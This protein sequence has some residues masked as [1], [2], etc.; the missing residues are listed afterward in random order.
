MIEKK[1]KDIIIKKINLITK[2]MNQKI[3]AK[4]CNISER[5]IFKIMH[6]QG[7]DG[8]FLVVDREVDKFIKELIVKLK[9]FLQKDNSHD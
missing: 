1:E 8:Q 3:L 6:G 4:R 9:K 5:S 7:S 2:T